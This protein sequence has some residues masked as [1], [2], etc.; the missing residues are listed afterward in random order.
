M[1]DSSGGKVAYGGGWNKAER[2][3]EPT[4]IL[5]PKRDSE[6]MEE[7]IFGPVLPILTFNNISEAISFINKKDK[8]LTVYYFGRSC[9]NS[10]LDRVVNETTSG[11]VSVNDVISHL[12]NSSFGFGGVGAS[13]YG[14]YGGFE[15]FKQFSNA[16]SIQVKPQMWMPLTP[17]YSDG[18]KRLLRNL[19]KL[20]GKQAQYL[21][22]IVILIVLGLLLYLGL[23]WERF[24]YQPVENMC[25]KHF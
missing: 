22:A 24:F 8:P 3:V 5:D 17:P 4:I 2:F 12:S 20:P 6:L 15:G 25:K 14:R 18:R 13:G 16:K 9:C 21:W 1:I 10:N 7:E 11:A 19:I 23:N